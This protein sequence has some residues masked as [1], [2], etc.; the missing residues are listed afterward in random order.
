ML[1]VQSLYLV[2]RIW[3]ELTASYIQISLTRSWGVGR[4]ADEGLQPFDDKS[5]QA[6][7]K[8][9]VQVVVAVVVRTLDAGFPRFERLAPRFVPSTF[10]GQDMPC[11]WG[12]QCGADH[13]G[14]LYQSST[15]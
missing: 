14:H 13:V 3:D 12:R 6:V 5:R 10:S 15:V 8:V 4:E 1:A 11:L 9:R 2:D 7:V